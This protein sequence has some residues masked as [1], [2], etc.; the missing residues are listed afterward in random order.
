MGQHIF[1]KMP[2][3]CCGIKPGF[4]LVRCVGCGRP[5]E[6]YLGP[7]DHDEQKAEID[8]LRHELKGASDIILGNHAHA[9]DPV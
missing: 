9:L 8:F 7:A 5:Q 2:N 3:Y 4:I 1:E 6:V